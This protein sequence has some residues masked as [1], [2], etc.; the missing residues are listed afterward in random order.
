MASRTCIYLYNGYT[1]S[2]NTFSIVGGLLIAFYNGH[3]HVL[4][5]SRNDFF[6]ER[7]FS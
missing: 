4:L 6:K 7:G 3:R 1:E 5:K 2:L